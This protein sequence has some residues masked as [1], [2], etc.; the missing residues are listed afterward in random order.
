MRG[1]GFAVVGLAAA[2]LGACQDGAM[3]PGTPGDS[4]R[5]E[6]EPNRPQMGGATGDFGGDCTCDVTSR[7]LALSEP[8]DVLGFSAE[9]V[10]ARI[11]GEYALTMIWGDACVGPLAP[12]EGCADEAPDFTGTETEVQIAIERAATSAL[13]R[14]CNADLG[15]HECHITSMIVPVTGSLTSTDGL[16]D[17]PFEMDVQTLSADEVGVYQR[18][19]AEDVGGSLPSRTPGLDHVEWA[20]V[21][22]GT[23]ARFEVFVVTRSPEATRSRVVSQ[24][25]EGGRNPDGHSWGV[26]V[27][28]E[29]AR[30]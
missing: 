1:L 4:N 2:I 18:L 12:D 8:D 20:F 26:E 10:L 24:P 17:E 15:D 19:Q 27:D 13:V 11:E 3:S 9:D 16:L 5:Q 7:E 28:L 25:P 14:E 22:S 23:D 21:V 6:P 30:Q 29:Q